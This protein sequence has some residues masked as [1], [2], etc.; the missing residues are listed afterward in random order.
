MID[1]PT[2][3]VHSHILENECIHSNFKAFRLWHFLCLVLI[4]IYTWIDNLFK[5]KERE[6]TR[7]GNHMINGR[8][9]HEENWI[10]CPK[11]WTQKKVPSSPLHIVSHG[12]HLFSWYTWNRQT[13]THTSCQ[14]HQRIISSC[15]AVQMKKFQFAFFYFCFFWKWSISESY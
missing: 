14:Q 10:K 13:R 9:P 5:G 15:F 1:T 6:L 4:A 8:K 12:S 7:A 3:H 11:K 2:C